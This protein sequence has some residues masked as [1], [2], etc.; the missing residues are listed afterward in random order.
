MNKNPRSRKAV[1]TSL[2]RLGAITR[3]PLFW[4]LT[5]AAMA[6]A[7]GAK[8]RRAALRGS[9][10]YLAGAVVGNVPKPVFGRAQPRF[11][12][13]K[14][15]Q[16]ARGSFPSGHAA[17]EVAYVFG[18]AQ[19]A[20]LSFLPL[21]AAAL[22]GLMSLV[23]EGKHYVS[24]TLVGGTMGLVVALIAFKAWRPSRPAPAPWQ[25]NSSEP[26]SR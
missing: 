15:P 16:I 1:P 24:D 19:E 10:C 8:G 6:A 4:G 23:K 3:Q 11:R 18:V 2:G 26:I 9:V 12:R 20:P 22:V 7:G 25:G 14:K 5:T 13:T 17:A 21:G